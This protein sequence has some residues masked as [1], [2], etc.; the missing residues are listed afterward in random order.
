M[1]MFGGVSDPILSLIL[2]TIIGL[3]GSVL[4]IYIGKK[5]LGTRSRYVL[6]C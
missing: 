6:G 4:V 5:I 2:E 3:G 1:N